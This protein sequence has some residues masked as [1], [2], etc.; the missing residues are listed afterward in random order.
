[1]DS[2]PDTIL[3]DKKIP[4]RKNSIGKKVLD[5]CKTRKLLGFGESVR[6]QF[7]NRSN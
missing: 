5:A 3:L 1:M 6:R 7:L 2:I 4:L